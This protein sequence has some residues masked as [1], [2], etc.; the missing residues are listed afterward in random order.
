[1]R[2]A[3]AHASMGDKAE[4]HRLLGI[5]E[6]QFG[7]GTR[8][9]DPPCVGWF[10]E[11]SLHDQAAVCHADLGDLRRAD[12]LLDK[13]QER[14]APT[15][16]RDYATYLIRRAQVQNDLGNADHAADLLHQVIPMVEQA[17]SKRNIGRL[18]AAR[19]RLPKDARHS[20]LDQRLSALTA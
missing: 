13:A 2:L 1:M 10:D 19:D 12:A 16:R 7:R 11:G 20:D 8:D 3:C 14:F 4:S 5:A 6:T 15:R 9:D 17:P 18:L